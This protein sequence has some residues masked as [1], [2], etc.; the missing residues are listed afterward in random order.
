MYKHM[1]VLMG[2]WL[3]II[4]KYLRMTFT[5]NVQTAIFPDGSV[6]VYFM[7][8]LPSLN[9]WPGLSPS[10]CSTVTFP[11]LSTAVG[12]FHVTTVVVLPLSE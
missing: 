6:A 7:V 4:F 11:E 8:L 10:L 9:V 1:Y 3:Y 5:A 12:G 2:L